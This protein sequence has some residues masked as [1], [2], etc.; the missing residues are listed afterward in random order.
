M[1]EMGLP[2][3]LGRRSFQ[4]R[5]YQPRC[6]R[7]EFPSRHC[8]RDHLQHAGYHVSRR[9]QVC[10]LSY[11]AGVLAIMIRSGGLLL[12]LP[13]RVGEVKRLSQS[14]LIDFL[15]IFF[16]F[17]APT[18]HAPPHCALFSKICSG[19]CLR[20]WMLGSTAPCWANSWDWL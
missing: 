4:F 12:K 3:Y 6:L 17:H 8:G 19:G 13:G 20:G 5:A 9:F 1:G 14:L 10:S 16:S 11:A 2:T 15:L 18:L 7:A